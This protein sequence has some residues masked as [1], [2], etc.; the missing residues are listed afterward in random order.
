MKQ[1][2]LAAF[3]RVQGKAGEA[4][5]AVKEAVGAGAAHGDL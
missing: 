5:E 1:H 2:I 3:D 4:A